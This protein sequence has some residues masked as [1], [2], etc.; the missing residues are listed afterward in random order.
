MFYKK[1]QFLCENANN[2]TLAYILDLNKNLES[3]IEEKS[4]TIIENELTSS[5]KWGFVPKDSRKQLEDFLKNNIDDKF[6]INEDG[7]INYIINENSFEIESDLTNLVNKLIFDS[8]K[9]TILSISL[10]LL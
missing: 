6:Y 5:R 10:F 9:L 4:N 2:Y 3:N 1:Q 8:E 7:F